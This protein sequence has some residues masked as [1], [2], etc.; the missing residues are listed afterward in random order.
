MLWVIWDDDNKIKKNVYKSLEVNDIFF[1]NVLWD[2]EWWELYICIYNIY[3]Y[4]YL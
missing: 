4:I 2:E 3:V 1:V